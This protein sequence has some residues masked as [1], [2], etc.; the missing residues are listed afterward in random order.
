MHGMHCHGHDAPK[1]FGFG[2]NQL[3]DMEFCHFYIELIRF[4]LGL[5]SAYYF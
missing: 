1:I 2:Y 5:Q 3:S 4:D